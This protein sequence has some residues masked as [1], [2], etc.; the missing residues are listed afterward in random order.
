M[1]FSGTYAVVMI[2]QKGDSVKSIEPLAGIL[3]LQI[4][5]WI[6]LSLSAIV[7]I[8]KDIGQAI[9]DRMLSF[10]EA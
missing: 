10:F 7:L 5:V 2:L 4:V 9:V 6:T 1:M 8:A 3:V